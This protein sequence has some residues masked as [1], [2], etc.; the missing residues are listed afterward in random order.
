MN[1]T[2]SE[3]NTALK[4]NNFKQME[5]IPDEQETYKMKHKPKFEP[6]INIETLKGGNE[7][8]NRM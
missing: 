3:Y 8:G 5:E 7:N 6:K 4:D 1:V 2:M